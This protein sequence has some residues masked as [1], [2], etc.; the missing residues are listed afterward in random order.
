MAAPYR[1]IVDEIRA[2]IAAGRLRPGD[3]VPSARQ[4]TQE[5]GVAI[6]TA[7]KALATLQAEGL[8][9]A[10][11]GVGTVVATPAVATPATTATPAPTATPATTATPAATATHGSATPG[12]L[13]TDS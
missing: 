12:A 5:W 2:R 4:I 8:V 7:T 3:R 11:V 6:A 10:V 1:L 9:R 13:V